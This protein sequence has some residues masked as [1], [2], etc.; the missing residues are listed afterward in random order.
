MP[1]S[2]DVPDTVSET[3]VTA[4]KEAREGVRSGDVATARERVDVAERI[5]RTQLPESDVAETLTFGLEAVDRTAA[6]EPLVASE[7]LRSMVQ[8]LTE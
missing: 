1:D 2:S 5:I 4:L 8:L 3:L 6:D 7:Y